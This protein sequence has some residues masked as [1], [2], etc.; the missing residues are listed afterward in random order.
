MEAR[1][2]VPMSETPE[3]RRAR[4]ARQREENARDLEA[5]LERDYLGPLADDLAFAQCQEEHAR[6]RMK[7]M[8][9]QNMV[10]Q[11]KLDVKKAQDLERRMVEKI[12]KVEERA[13][14]LQTGGHVPRPGD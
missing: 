8:E 10:I 5:E 3:E 9:F 11:G 14:E 2:R 13:R 7:I 1:S 12:H 4:K 6:L